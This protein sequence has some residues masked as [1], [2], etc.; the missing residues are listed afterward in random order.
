[1]KTFSR[2]L[3]YDNVHFAYF[4]HERLLDRREFMSRECDAKSDLQSF[5]VSLDV[6]K[7]RF[8]QHDFIMSED[9]R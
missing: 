3:N 1:M 8:P 7:A 5:F 4:F 6:R 2:A 9:K